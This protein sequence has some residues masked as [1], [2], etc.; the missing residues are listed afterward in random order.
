MEQLFERLTAIN[1]PLVIFAFALVLY[2]V[3]TFIIVYHLT[4]FGIGTKS[5][6]AALIFFVG[7]LVLLMIFFTIYASLDTQAIGDNFAKLFTSF[8]IKIPLP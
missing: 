3:Y 4:R 2:F 1:A 7:T 5:K 8:S 6:L